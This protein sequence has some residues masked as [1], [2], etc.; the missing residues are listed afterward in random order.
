M[1]PKLVSQH[2][3]IALVTHCSRIDDSSSCDTDRRVDISTAIQVRDKEWTVQIAGCDDNTR[4]CV[5]LVHIVLGCRDI[6]VLN[7]IG[8]S[9]H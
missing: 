8:A 3:H 9:I 1:C 2:S 7:T 5:H 6:D 4:F